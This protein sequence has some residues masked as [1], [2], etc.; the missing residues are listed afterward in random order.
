L[1]FRATGVSPW[2]STIFLVAIHT[3]AADIVSEYKRQDLQVGRRID[4]AVK[5]S[6]KKNAIVFI[7]PQDKYELIVDSVFFMNTPDLTKQ[8]FIF[9]KDLG[10]NNKR[11]LEFYTGRNGFLYRHRKDINKYMEEDIVFLH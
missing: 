1:G 7:E 2:V 6:E 5:K 3:R 10:Q 8:D 9:A 11:L 4:H